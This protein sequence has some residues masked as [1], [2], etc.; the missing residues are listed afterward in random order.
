MN[1][2]V[3]EVVARLEQRVKSEIAAIYAGYGHDIWGDETPSE[4]EF[5][6]VMIDQ[7]SHRRMTPD[8]RSYWTGLT[9][10]EKRALALKVGP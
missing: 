5:A 6:D 4:D 7:M 10:A 1:A 3:S 2:T 8:I 9:T